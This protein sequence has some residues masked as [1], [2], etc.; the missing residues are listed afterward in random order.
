MLLSRH[1]II[2]NTKNKSQ[3]KTGK[4]HTKIISGDIKAS[5]IRPGANAEIDHECKEGAD[6]AASSHL[7]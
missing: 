1:K 5:N 2:R 4:F 7:L 3:N 6:S